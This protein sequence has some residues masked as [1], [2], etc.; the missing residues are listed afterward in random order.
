MPTTGF[1]QYSVG[2]PDWAGLVPYRKTPVFRALQ[3]AFELDEETQPQPERKT[4]SDLGQCTET[5][6]DRFSDRPA[7]H[8]W[9][10]ERR[11]SAEQR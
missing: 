8:L 5:S 7:R 11:L 1:R 3:I 10:A 9:R 6:A 4:V 2:W